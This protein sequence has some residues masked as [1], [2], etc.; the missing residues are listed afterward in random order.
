MKTKVFAM[1]IELFVTVVGCLSHA[2]WVIAAMDGSSI[3]PI[4]SHVNI[5]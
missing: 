3:I 2:S 4:E 5:A 1:E